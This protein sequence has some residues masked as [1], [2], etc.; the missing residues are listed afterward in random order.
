MLQNGVAEEQIG[1][2][3]LYR[4]QI[5]LLSSHLIDHQGIEILTADRSQ[6]RDKDCILISLV[7]ANAENKVTDLLLLTSN[8][9]MV[10]LLDRRPAERLATH[11][12]SFHQGPFEARHI[13]QPQDSQ[14][15][16]TFG[17]LLPVDG[18]E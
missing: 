18:V 8:G 10:F 7:R 15:F 13:W 5:K 2:I 3:S 17:G 1:I 11:Q 4:Q 16:I 14:C 9:F 6:G 12:R